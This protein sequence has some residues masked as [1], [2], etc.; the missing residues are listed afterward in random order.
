M[1]EFR[2][3]YFAEE[4]A[5]SAIEQRYYSHSP[6]SNADPS[7]NT[8]APTAPT[9]NPIPVIGGKPFKREPEEKQEEETS[10]FLYRSELDRSRESP[11]PPP[12]GTS[13]STPT[14]T[15]IM[16]NSQSKVAEKE[17]GEEKGEAYRTMETSM[18]AL[19][20]C[21]EDSFVTSLYQARRPRMIANLIEE[22]DGKASS[23]DLQAYDDLL[24]AERKLYRKIQEQLGL[25]PCNDGDVPA[26]QSPS[27]PVEKESSSTGAEADVESG[28]SDS[29]NSQLPPY[30]YFSQNPPPT[31]TFG[32]VARRL[33]SLIS[34]RETDNTEPARRQIITNG[35]FYPSSLVSP[36]PPP[37]YGDPIY[38]AMSAADIL[39]GCS[40]IS[41]A[42][43]EYTKLEI[44]SP[45]KNN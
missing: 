40:P 17:G 31:P 42:S 15:T 12:P 27:S 25:V 14:T 36:P 3:K 4:V 45:S 32:G 37:T 5:E 34:N 10:L 20:N 43:G 19:G 11:E 26:D 29:W 7:S 9:L 13:L 8:S 18:S 1:K 41:P 23:S 21:F 33:S 2:D 30:S 38:A 24:N 44:V 28:N 35:T 6:S 16:G 39:P 22:R